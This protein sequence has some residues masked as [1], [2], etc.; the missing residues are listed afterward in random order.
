M[1][2]EGIPSPLPLSNKLYILGSNTNMNHCVNG[3]AYF[4][5]SCYTKLHKLYIFNDVF[6]C[7]YV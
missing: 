4:I 5:Y 1:A 7:V 6:F 2:Q 3:L